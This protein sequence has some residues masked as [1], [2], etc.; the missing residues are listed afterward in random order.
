MTECAGPR[1]YARV[2]ETAHARVTARTGILS[3]DKTDTPNASGDPQQSLGPRRWRLESGDPT[4]RDTGVYE[5]V[6]NN[7]EGTA[8]SEPATIAVRPPACPA[9]VDGSGEADAFDL[10]QFL[11]ALNDGCPTP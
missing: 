5:L 2:H 7:S 8:L 10:F 4:I 3:L 11:D 6:I 9:D 1:R